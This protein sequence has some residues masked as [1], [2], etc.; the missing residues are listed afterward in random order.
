[1]FLL[2]TS[3]PSEHSQVEHSGRLAHTCS[4]EE[5]SPTKLPE[6]SNTIELSPPH[7]GLYD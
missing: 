7:D 5:S 6:L 4:S 2:P 1:C 3:S